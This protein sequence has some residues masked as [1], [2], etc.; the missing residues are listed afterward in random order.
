MPLVAFFA[1]QRP[2]VVVGNGGGPLVGYPREVKTADYFQAPAGQA[3]SPSPIG[4]GL[5]P[6]EFAPT[7][8]KYG[9]SLAIIVPYK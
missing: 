2:R 6:D 3:E 5:L 4:W 1:V 9:E 7:F 8:R